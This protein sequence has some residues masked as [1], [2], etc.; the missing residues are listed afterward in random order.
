MDK[1]TI[2]RLHALTRRVRESKDGRERKE[3]RKEIRSIL[4]RA[5]G[6]IA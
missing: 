6:R 4:Y 2:A 1:E 3:I 5:I